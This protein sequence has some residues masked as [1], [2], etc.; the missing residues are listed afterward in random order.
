MADSEK[1]IADYRIVSRLGRGGMGVVYKGMH[2]HSGTPAAIKILPSEMAKNQ[3]IIDRFLKEAHAAT[4]LNHRNIVRIYEAG[5]FCG[6]Y[7]IALEYIDGETLANA[8]E[9]EGKIPL[10]VALQITAQ[11]AKGLEH[12]HER[13]IIHRDIKPGN[14]MITRDKTAK[15][16][17]M[18]LAYLSHSRYHDPTKPGFTVGTPAYMSP[19]QVMTPDKMDTRSDI[20]SLGATLYHMLLG[21]P[22]H[23]GRN[24]EEVMTK[25]VKEEV[26]YPNAL[27]AGVVA[28]LKK[29]LSKEPSLRF[30]NARAVAEAIEKFLS[31]SKE[32]YIN[33]GEKVKVVGKIG[34]RKDERG[35]GGKITKAATMYERAGKKEPNSSDGKGVLTWCYLSC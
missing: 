20:Y 17:D 14:I 6:L 2:I 1:I 24:A 21:R 15:I 26:H 18:G 35:I 33:K 12:A 34:G 7:Y 19:E 29:M 11:V 28:I 5:E 31:P 3:K 22:P 13:G 32:T 10:K 4:V 27:P 23:L 25:V 30:K 16:T 8:L 9:R